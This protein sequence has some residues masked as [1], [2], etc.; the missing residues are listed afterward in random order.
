MTKVIALLAAVAAAAAAI[1]TAV[2]FQR[3]K[4]NASRWDSAKN[5]A[6]SWGKAAAHGAGKAA[7]KVAGR[8]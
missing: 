3:K 2:F 1:L 7:D 8:G 5:S 4:R 6:S